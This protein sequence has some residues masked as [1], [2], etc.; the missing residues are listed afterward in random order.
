MSRLWCSR[1]YSN[2]TRLVESIR[3][4]G[5]LKPSGQMLVPVTQAALGL[6]S[7]SPVQISING[8]VPEV[9][10]CNKFCN[11][12]STL[13][14]HPHAVRGFCC[15]VV[16]CRAFLMVKNR[17]SYCSSVVALRSC[18]HKTRQHRFPFLFNMCSTLQ[19]IMEGTPQKESNADCVFIVAVTACRLDL[20]QQ[21]HAAF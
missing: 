15:N 9:K 7:M 10:Q 13:W 1:I 8:A 18:F 11:L 20:P 2:L 4:G 5:N 14:T 3:A 19:C 21:K 17:D 12:P 16:P 6:S